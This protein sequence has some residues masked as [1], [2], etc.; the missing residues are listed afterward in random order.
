[1]SNARRDHSSARLSRWDG[2][3]RR[4]LADAVTRLGRVPAA[5]VAPVVTD[6]DLADL[7]PPAQRYLRWMG[8]VGAPRV[9][10]VHAR[11]RGQIRLKPGQRWMPFDGWQFDAAVPITRLIHMR[12]AVAGLIPM[13]GTDTYAQGVGRMHGKLLGLVTVADGEGPEFDLGE[14]V[15]WLNDAALL[16]PSMLLIPACRWTAVDDRSFDVTVTDAANVVTAR[17]VVDDDGRLVDFRTD[18]R[19]YAGTN[20]P[21]RATWST[22]LDGWT[23]TTDGRPLP[24]TASAVWHLPEGD[25]TYVRGA[26]D[27]ALVEFDRAPSSTV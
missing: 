9:A 20:P 27:P 24:T 6:L 10:T 17:F 21:T 5:A 11:F 4:N 3:A 23:T 19:W 12:I 25:F 8:V 14:L 18:D 7:P 13:F 1:M 16:A 26:F 22:P 2:R 15:T